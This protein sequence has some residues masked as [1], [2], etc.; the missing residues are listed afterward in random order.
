MNKLQQEKRQGFTEQM[1]QKTDEELQDILKIKHEYQPEAAEAA[2]QVAAERGLLGDDPTTDA[3]QQVESSDEWYYQYDGEKQGPVKLPAIQSLIKTKVIDSETL[4]WKQGFDQWKPLYDT[5]LIQHVDRQEP[6]P[7]PTQSEE[8][9]LVWFVKL[10]L[11]RVFNFVFFFAAGLVVF[12]A[13][14][15]DVIWGRKATW[16]DY[17]IG[18]GGLKIRENII[19]IEFNSRYYG[20]VNVTRFFDSPVIS[21][22]LL[23]LSLGLVYYAFR[24]FF[25][26]YK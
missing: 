20:F 18:D 11:R 25:Y 22:M 13:G 5:P 14:G 9:M 3:K 4:V 21:Y 23:F 1:Q 12:L 17:L 6:P 19:A 10:L 26:G 24:F 16:F 7:L 8:N 2:M 15:W